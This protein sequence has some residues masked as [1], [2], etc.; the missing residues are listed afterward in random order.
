MFEFNQKNIIVTG[1]SS[2]IG[3]ALVSE[4]LNLGANIW[5]LARNE[6]KIMEV[7]RELQNKSDRINYFL[8]D[9]QNFEE[10]KKIADEL[11]QDKIEIHGLINSAGVAHPAE[12]D[13]LSI[14]QYHWLMDINYFGTVHSVLAFLPRMNSG[15]FISNISSMAGLIGVYGYSGYGASKFAVRGF[16]DVL[17][18]ELKLK[19][20]QVSIVFP[21]DTDTPQLEYENQIKPEITKKIAGSANILSASKV[22]NDII[23]GIQKEK[24][25]IIPGLE[26]KLI[27]HASNFLG[28]LFYPLMDLMLFQAVKQINRKK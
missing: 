11:R 28:P 6:E 3:K 13:K 20:I 2:G 1:G 22:A 16:T 15:S 4:L 14:E 18:S 21:P 24:Y 17:R 9:V 25:L 26:S 10:L 5:I 12:F 23:R 7:K 27:Y 8:V 19:G